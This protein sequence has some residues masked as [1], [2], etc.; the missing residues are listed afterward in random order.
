MRNKWI[1]F[2]VFF[3]LVINLSALATLAYNRWLKPGPPVEKEGLAPFQ[4]MLED[5]LE[6]ES[7]Q[8]KHMREC[9][10]EFC[11]EA[12]PIQEQ[13]QEK[14]LRLVEEMR[15]SEP[16]LEEIDKLIDEIV[17]LESSVQKKAVRRI[18]ED[19]AILMPLQQER[20]LE[21]FEHHVIRGGREYCPGEESR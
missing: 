8:S 9:R 18:L 16:S 5:T 3:L 10:M 21:M 6:L 14:R 11:R 12:D 4:P 19:K 13:I 7:V 1:G 2:I 17:R 15:K 20:F